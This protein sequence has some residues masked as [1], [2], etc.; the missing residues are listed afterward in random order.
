VD[1]SD[2][3]ELHYITPIENLPSILK[4][5]ILSHSRVESLDHKSVAMADVQAR[6]AAKRIPG[7]R[8]L[9]EY[10]NLYFNARNVMMFT[11]SGQHRD[12]CV[13]RIRPDVLQLEGVVITDRNAA[14]GICRWGVYPDD[15]ARLDHSRVF[16]ERWNLHEDEMER[17]R[18]R[19]EMCAEALIPD[20][21]LPEDIVGAYVSCTASAAKTR[22]LTPNLAV[23]V[24]G[25]M[26]F[27]TALGRPQ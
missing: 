7:G 27:F 26:F 8:R 14:T 21:V 4:H 5:G 12:L 15:L 11:R 22:E 1:A 9:H 13:L 20:R 16:A 23:T 10:A 25:Y 6:R 17:L 24:N 18:H 19:A 2:V 3:K